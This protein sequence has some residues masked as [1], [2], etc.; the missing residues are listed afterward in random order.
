MDQPTVRTTDGPPIARRTVLEMGCGL[1]GLGLLAACSDDAPLPAPTPTATPTGWVAPASMSFPDGFVWGAATSAFQVEGSTTA[2]GRGPSIW[3][4]FCAQPGRIDDGSTGDPA[5][6]QYVRWESDLDL[7]VGLGLQAYR[8]SVSWPRIVPEGSGPVNQ[9]GVDHYR[10]LVDGML[11]RGLHPAITLYHW[12]LPQPLQDAGGWVNRDTADRFAEYAA[13]MFE[14]LRD[15]EATWL[16]INEPK[17]TAMV[18][19][20]GTEHAPGLGDLDAGMASVHHQLLAHGKAVRAFRSVGGAG[21]I[22]IALNLMPVYPAEGAEQAARHLDAA[23]NRLYLDPVLLGTYPDDAVGDLPGQLGAD[24]DAFEALVLDDD[25]EVIS[26]P[27]DVLAV[28]YYG[29][30]GIDKG[31]SWLQLYPRSPAGWQQVH[32]EGLYETLVGL[33]A[34]YPDLPPLVISENGTP[35]PD[36]QGQIDDPVRLEFLRTHLQQA[37][38]AVDEGVDLRQYYAWSLLDN[39]EW[40][41]GMAQ[42]WGIVHVDF[43]TQERTPK[44]SARWY[45]GVVAANAVA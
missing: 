11:D 3:D 4:T 10:R 25:L 28:Q 5:A 40:A 12:D 30:A 24:R 39:F 45:A 1:V 44:A 32:A 20:A 27:C 14:A 2:D 37:A 6:D 7:M 8:F 33:R 43:D 9:K 23:E 22:G 36:P 19:Y 13:V 16:T 15:V 18:G 41:R 29:V 17:T 34:D 35:D 31:G 42:R 21:G 38:R 26:S